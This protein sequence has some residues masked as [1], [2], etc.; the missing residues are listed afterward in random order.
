VL[1]LNAAVPLHFCATRD[2]QASRLVRFEIYSV[3]GQGTCIFARVGNDRHAEQ[4]FITAAI[5]VP[6]T[7]ESECGDSWSQAHF[8][9]RSVFIVADGLGHGED[10]AEAAQ[11]AIQI[12]HRVPDLGPKPMLQRIHDALRK[13]RGA[14]VA[15]AEIDIERHRLLYAGV[16]NIFSSVLNNGSTYS[17][18]SHNGTLGHTLS[19]IQEFSYT[20]TPQ[21]TLVMQSDGLTSH[22]DL[23]RYPGLALKHPLLIAGVLYRDAK[24]GRDDATVLVSRETGK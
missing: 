10:A 11:E 24:R 13:T 23:W 14:A 2:S 17:M 15:V 22:W 1:I 19:R 9:G 18:V 21:S 20:W 12:F 16:G 4:A 3:L 6:M 5:S 8:P 7:G